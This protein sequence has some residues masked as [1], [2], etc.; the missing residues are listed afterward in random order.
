VVDL[1]TVAESGLA[2]YEVEQWYGIAAPLR[3][4]KPVV[5]ALHTGFTEA[6]RAPDV[7]QRLTADGSVLVGNTPEQFGD[8][9]KSEIVKW[10]KL[11]KA[12]NLK[13][14]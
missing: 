12:A 1:P 11:V 14:Q 9:I 6:L 13:V 2:G 4:R 3:V 10:T 8:Y 5:A 7:I